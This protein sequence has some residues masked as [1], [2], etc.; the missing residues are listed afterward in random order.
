MDA[1][2]K[3]KK[4]GANA[5]EDRHLSHHLVRL[6]ADVHQQLKKLADRNNRP[7][8]WELRHLVIRHLEENGLWPP[9]AEGG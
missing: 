1:M 2:T 6:P 8:S 7:M 4:P 5:R 3:P 9:P